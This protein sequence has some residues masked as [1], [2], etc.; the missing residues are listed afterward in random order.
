MEGVSAAHFAHCWGGARGGAGF[1][2]NPP[3]CKPS[4][5]FARETLHV[6][7]R[8]ASDKKSVSLPYCRDVLEATG[9]DTESGAAEC[10]EGPVACQ[11]PARLARTQHCPALQQHLR[12]QQTMASALLCGIRDPEKR[13]LLSPS[14]LAVGCVSL[15]PTPAQANPPCCRWTWRPRRTSRSTAL[16]LCSLSAPPPHA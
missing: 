16:S 11:C 5:K 2:I 6:G 9:A 12:G 1:S 10:P 8:E 4:L 3:E 13:P 14:A 7:L 15:P